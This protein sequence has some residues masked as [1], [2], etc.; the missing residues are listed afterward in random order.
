MKIPF[1]LRYKLHLPPKLMCRQVH[2]HKVLV[3]TIYKLFECTC[4]NSVYAMTS[5]NNAESQLV[6]NTLN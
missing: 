5:K 2:I 3:A 6:S 1:T 4:P